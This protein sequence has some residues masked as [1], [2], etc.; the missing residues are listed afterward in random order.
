MSVF[1]KHQF[2]ETMEDRKC[3]Q[4]H[5]VEGVIPNFD[6]PD[7]A[8]PFAGKTCDCGRFLFD[9]EDCGCPGWEKG[10]IVVKENQNYGNN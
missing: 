2:P 3:I 7:T 9:L 1:K 4:A 8:Y 6:T 10:K 5:T